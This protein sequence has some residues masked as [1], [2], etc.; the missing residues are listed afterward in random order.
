MRK[1]TYKLR[2]ND[3]PRQEYVYTCTQEAEALLGAIDRF[4]TLN[5]PFYADVE[6]PSSW[7]SM[8]FSQR[9]KYFDENAID[10]RVFSILCRPDSTVTDEDVLSFSQY[11]SVTQLFIQG[12]YVTSASVQVLNAMPQ[13]TDLR[14]SGD[15]F[16]DEITETVCHL[17]KL[18]SLS[19]EETRL[20]LS[21]VNIIKQRFEK[22]AELWLPKGS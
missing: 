9:K 16:G 19:L 7:K 15:Q 1:E 21:A 5:A 22:Q 4:D 17:E 13:L 14:I 10:L 11:T 20:S 6:L 12:Q 3:G 8:S 2:E 18:K